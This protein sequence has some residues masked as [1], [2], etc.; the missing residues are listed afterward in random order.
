MKLAGFAAIPKKFHQTE[1]SAAGHFIFRMTIIWSFNFEFIQV[2]TILL[3][4]DNKVNPVF[5]QEWSHPLL[6]I[7]YFIQ[8][9]RNKNFRITQK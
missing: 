2:A 3:A 6:R 9:K 1:K 4:S 5:K 8:Q 7:V